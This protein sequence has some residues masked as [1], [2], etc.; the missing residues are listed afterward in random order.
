MRRTAARFA[1]L[2]AVLALGLA[3][4]PAQAGE[5]RPKLEPK[6]HAAALIKAFKSDDVE[7]RLDAALEAKDVQ[8]DS[9]TSP[10]VKLLADKQERFA[11]AEDQLAA[12]RDVD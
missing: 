9:L 3:L 10:L 1:G 12:L 4:R 6:A 2:A 7:V 5:E 11:S 8:H